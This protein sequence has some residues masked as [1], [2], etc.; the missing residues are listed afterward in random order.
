MSKSVDSSIKQQSIGRY[1][2]PPSRNI[3]NSRS[4]CICC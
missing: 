2:G 4:T 3:P 1:I